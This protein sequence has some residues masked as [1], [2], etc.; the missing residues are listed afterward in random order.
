MSRPI[1]IQ[2]L[3]SRR[4]TSSFGLSELE[5]FGY[6]KYSHSL[7]ILPIC[8]FTDVA[9]YQ[10]SDHHP[11]VEL[12]SCPRNPRRRD[13][14]VHSFV[15]IVPVQTIRWRQISVRSEGKIDRETEDERRGG[16]REAETGD[17]AAWPDPTRRRLQSNRTLSPSQSCM[18]L[19]EKNW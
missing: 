13:E 11:F 12:A 9:E 5:R 14:K 18:K 4:S 10:S 15:R 16:D 2:V 3:G 8:H 17:N 7:N 6:N 1:I 19:D